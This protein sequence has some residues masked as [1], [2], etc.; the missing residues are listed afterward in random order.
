M[1]KRNL[2]VAAGL[3]VLL[4]GC[5]SPPDNAAGTSSTTTGGTTPPSTA[6]S[7]PAETAAP[8]AVSTPTVEA[9]PDLEFDKA[10]A[11]KGYADVKKLGKNPVAGD[12]EATK[13]GATLFATNCASCHGPA[14]LGDGP[15]GMALNPKPRNLTAF[16]EYKYGKGDLGLFRTIKYGVDGSGMAPWEGRMTDDECWKVVNFVRTLQ[17]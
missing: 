12:V 14:G 10:K 15:A 8:V 13:A 11:M 6:T 4:V 3:T 7:A 1:R 16:A 9:A 5:T 2:I 17:K